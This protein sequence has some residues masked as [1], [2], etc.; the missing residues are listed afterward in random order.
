MTVLSFQPDMPALID[1]LIKEHTMI[2]SPALPTLTPTYVSISHHLGDDPFDTHHIHMDAA[3]VT[4]QVLV[5]WTEIAGWDV[6]YRPA[7]LIS[8]RDLVTITGLDRDRA[9]EAARQAL[10]TYGIEVPA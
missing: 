9:I 10:A 1:Q 3:G 6:K 7:E 2:D 5:S 8:W 4:G